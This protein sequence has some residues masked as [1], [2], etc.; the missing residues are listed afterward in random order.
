MN[1]KTLKATFAIFILA[2]VLF[3]SSIISPNPVHSQPIFSN[4]FIP[5]GIPPLSKRTAILSFPL[6]VFPFVNAGQGSVVPP[7]TFQELQSIMIIIEDRTDGRDTLSIN[8]DFLPLTASAL[9]SGLALYK[10]SGARRGGF[11]FRIG[12]Q[13]SDTPIDLAGPPVVQQ[14]PANPRR[15]FVTFRPIVGSAKLSLFQDQFPDFYIVA[16]TSLQI[17]HGDRFE[18]SI[19]QNGITIRDSGGPLVDNTVFDARF[20][21]PEFES[22]NPE[23]ARP[24]IFEGDL[25][26]LF[27]IINETDNTNRI[28]A[29][30]EPTTI[31]GLEMVGRP[32]Q[33]YFLSEV[34]V[35]WIGLNL[36]Q[37][38]RLMANRSQADY[39]GALIAGA[40]ASS[41]AGILNQVNAFPSFFYSPWFYNYPIDPESGEPLVSTV[42]TAFGPLEYPLTAPLDPNG[43]PLP[44]FTIGM[45]D[46]NSHVTSYTPSGPRLPFI[47]IDALTP[48]TVSQ[49]ILLPLSSSSAGGVFLYRELGGSKNKY[50]AGVDQI[51]KL[52]PNS[53]TVETF[54][55]TPEEVQDPNSPLSTIL[56]RLV[57]GVVSEGSA[58]DTVNF[59]FGDTN[60]AA[61]LMG[62]SEI[63]DAVDGFRAPYGSLACY[64]DPDCLF[65]D[66][67]INVLKPYLGLTEGQIRYLAEYTEENG[68]TNM[69]ELFGFPIVQGF[70][71]VM[72]ISRDNALS[73]ISVPSSRIAQSAGPDIFVGIRT[74]DKLRALDSFIP[75][76]RP[77]DLSVGTNVQNFT[78]NN[79]DGVVF[80]DS[81]ASIGVGR[82]NSGE[83]F[84]MIGRPRPRFQFEDLTQPGP[85][86][87]QANRN[88]I[89]FDSS[90][91]SPPKAV[92]GVDAIDFGQNP[93]RVQNSMGIA[94]DNFDVF[95]DESSVLGEAQIEFL[96]TQ[97]TPV[98]DPLIFNTI[99]V[100][101]NVDLPF[102]RIISQ[103]SV[104]F[105]IEDDTPPGNGVDDDFDGLVDEEDYNLIDDD[106][107]GLIDEDLG[108]G[109]PAGTNGEYDSFDRI[110]P[111]PG[112]RF[113]SPQAFQ[114]ATY[115]F[116]PNDD[117]KY[118]PYIDAISDPNNP[119]TLTQGGMLPLSN[120]DGSWFTELDLTALN[121]D[122]YQLGRFSIFPARGQRIPITPLAAPDFDPPL[123]NQGTYFPTLQPYTGL[124]D[125]VKAIGLPDSIPD[126]LIV[127]HPET[128][129]EAFLITLTA[130]GDTDIPVIEDP[131]G[132]L[133]RTIL[134]SLASALRFPNPQLGFVRVGNTPLIVDVGGPNGTNPTGDSQVENSIYQNGFFV[135]VADAQAIADY[136][137]D[138]LDQ[139]GDAIESAGDLQADFDEQV[140]DIIDDAASQDPPEPPDFSDLE[141]P[142]D[143]VEI[144]FTHPYDALGIQD[145]LDNNQGIY[146]TNYQYQLQIP[147]ENFGPLAGNDF[148]VV[149]RAGDT[150][151]TGDS[152]RVR[153]SSGQRNRQFTFTDPNDGTIQTVDAPDRGISYQ[154]FINTDTAQGTFFG[155]PNVSKNQ[156][157]TGPI[158]VRSANVPPSISFLAPSSQQNLASETLTYDVIFN[159]QDPDNVATIRLFVDVD[160]LNF[161]GTFIPGSQLREGFNNSFTL[162]LRRDI[163]N[164]DPTRPYFIYAEISDGVNAPVVTY[165]DGPIIAL[166]AGDGGDGGGNGSGGG[167]VVEGDVANEIDYIKLTNDGRIFSLGEMPR[168]DDI[169][170]TARTTDAEKTTNNTGAIILQD[171]GKVFGSG[172]IGIFQRRLQ[173]N[174]EVSFSPQETVFVSNQMSGAQTIIAPTPDQITI[175]FARD[176]EVDFV[177]GGIYILDGDG[178]MLYLG[179]ANSQL[180]PPAIDI[181]LYRDM[182]L[183]PDGTT[184]YFLTGNGLFS[185]VGPNRV[186]NWSNL[187]T[188]D[189]Y[190]DLELVLDGQSVAGILVVN[191]DG[192]VSAIGSSSRAA[193]L[194]NL[195]RDVS[196][197]AGTV[198]QIKTVP[199][200]PDTLLFVEGSGQVTA[201]SNSGTA[202]PRD[203]F[204]F[205]ENPGIDND[206]AVDIET[207][208]INL[209]TVVE[210]VR[211]VLD[212]FAKEDISTIMKHIAP[213]YK[214]RQG[215]TAQTL[216]RALQTYFNYYEIATFTESFGSNTFTITT[217]GD[218][219]NANV[220][221]DFA[222]FT[223]T[224][225][226][227]LPEVD[228][229][230]Q[231]AEISGTFLFNDLPFDQSIR[232]R[233]VSDGRSWTIELWDIRDFGRSIDDLIT[234][235]DVEFE[236]ITYLRTQTNNRRLGYYQPRSRGIDKPQ[237]YFID[238]NEDDPL[239]PIGLL[240]IFQEN[241]LRRDIAPPIIE[242]AAYFGSL[243]FALENDIDITFDIDEN[244]EQKITSLVL[245]NVL[246]E[247]PDITLTLDEED[248]DPAISNLDGQTS[249]ENMG[250]SFSDGGPVTALFPGEADIV[251]QG[252]E[253]VPTNPIGGVMMLPEGT[254]I[255]AV[256]PQVLINSLNRAQVIGNQF[257]PNSGNTAFP[258][259][260]ATATGGRS[261]LVLNADGKT[262]ALVSLF[263]LVGGDGDGDQFL[264]EY[265]YED[266]FILPRGF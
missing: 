15:F 143:P 2:P 67:L 43:F 32:D 154:S 5:T 244:G 141:F 41:Q 190:R 180:R 51:I 146:D 116:P 249:N 13:N 238:K 75:F 206:L 172:T 111:S 12:D 74:S 265:R 183:S 236:D 83:T 79:D 120:F 102:S 23:F 42:E 243:T 222:G 88:N 77:Q 54:G 160:N 48:D 71:F 237:S 50:D 52:N 234:S 250:F 127:T 82:P 215:N 113:G 155:F 22:L 16:Q 256:N 201:I 130:D 38:S 140:Q 226:F 168:F 125:L 202:I 40:L 7:R 228:T 92:I 53:F 232:L 165:A 104:A 184:M 213:D 45:D 194:V 94:P 255:F 73:N 230:T 84:T 142:P 89:L 44:A 14:D 149:L 96:P 182:E 193:N 220:L 21:G 9:S 210:I 170:V 86:P 117:A 211:E 156:I 90:L 205:A 214:D 58:L 126:D 108:D 162:D 241:A 152:F 147:D 253:L 99:P 167:I 181:D 118:Q 91:S 121:Y 33:G 107:D 246:F 137:G 31:M 186:G 233:D 93:N 81:V 197:G 19:P 260:S 223:P 266:T 192:I 195:S 208:S 55:I 70:R 11:N 66:L 3:V 200:S 145:F 235:D 47:G 136:V 65:F 103:H 229:S 110:L 64:E 204:V 189:K 248:P 106:G 257:D 78:Q 252:A 258:G 132:D 138:M 59:L 8:E 251:L 176:I 198:R 174:G 157:T 264:F 35:N 133:R 239:E 247:N 61:D 259:L 134:L 97:A 98:F 29:S 144:S 227:T 76:I 100:V 179:N 63:P 56:S 171:D 163:P 191:D 135:E 203:G 207:A 10:E 175:D 26:E 263:Q 27:S 105:Y 124:M 148:Y 24:S 173:P 131:D 185:T 139:L 158:V 188:E 49:D 128:G 254:D 262:F 217:S 209:K 219:V 212:A 37:I 261:Y 6:S 119:F 4:D 80:R 39:S 115:V 151:Q 112:D 161:D 178:D 101:L 17:L 199:N 221:I 69:E 177:N 25:F 30:S 216:E 187:I 231:A 114:Q 166:P 72:P 245:V 169:N 20:P 123:L 224:I 109:T 87:L 218:T 242:L 85:D 196:L 46:L 122:N 60:L 95:F 240:A 159:A 164:F 68:I 18:I 150:A 57:P 62:V 225:T 36:G 129:E 1:I 28:D 153:I 34:R